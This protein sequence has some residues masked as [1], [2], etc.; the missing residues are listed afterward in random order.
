MGAAF[1]PESLGR[2]L[3]IGPSGDGLWIVRDADG[4]C[5]AVFATRDEALRFAKSECAAAPPWSCE[6]RFVPALELTA[7]FTPR[8]RG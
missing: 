4:L 3:S 8:R 1:T 5:G 7:L 6:W 2:Q